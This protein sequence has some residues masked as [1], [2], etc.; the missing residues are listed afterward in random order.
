[1]TYSDHL[2]FSLQLSSLFF[3][4]SVKAFIHAFYPDILANSST[5]VNELIA[6]K[7]KASGCNKT[8]QTDLTTKGLLSFWKTS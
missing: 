6:K 4:G 3:V 2:L 5:E 1:M 7:I 8:T